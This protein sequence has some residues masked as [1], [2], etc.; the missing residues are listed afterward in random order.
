MCGHA[1]MAE[2][3]ETL[4]QVRPM[5]GHEYCRRPHS[6]HTSAETRVDSRKQPIKEEAAVRLWTDSVQTDPGKPLIPN[7]RCENNGPTRSKGSAK[8][9][10]TGIANWWCPHPPGRSSAYA[11]PSPASPAAAAYRSTRPA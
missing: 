10:V 9:G 11:P 4:P 3:C 7:H 6:R 2:D 1:P 8:N 5:A